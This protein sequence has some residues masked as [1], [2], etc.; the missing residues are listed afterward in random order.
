MFS[1]LDAQRRSFQKPQHTERFRKLRNSQKRQ[2]HARQVSRLSFESGE[3]VAH[4]AVNRGR[5]DCDIG[6]DGNLRV[7]LYVNSWLDESE[8]A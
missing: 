1:K 5:L 4:F 2:L 3:L 7:K 8:V 6:N